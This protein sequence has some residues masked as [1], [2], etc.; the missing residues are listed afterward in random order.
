MSRQRHRFQHRFRLL[1]LASIVLAL[2]VIVLPFD[3]AR[4]NF[5][6]VEAGHIY[7]SAA[8]S[9][10]QTKTLAERHGI[11]TIV[12]LGAFDRD[13]GKET[14][15]QRTAD[16]LG[17]RRHVFRLEGDGTG[18]PNQYVAALKLLADEANHPVLVHCATGAQRT[19]ACIILYRHIIQGRS[20]ESVYPEAFDYRHSP[21]DNWKLMAYL[22]DW[23]DE[24]TSSFESGRPIAG[25][26]PPP[27]GSTKSASKPAAIAADGH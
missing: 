1:A 22:A 6:V 24:I 13:K 8:L 19:G 17:V 18:N 14:A 10:A 15:A 23:T 3:G 20:I 4:R 27:A 5:G 9:P 21:G 25:F 7:R 26:P 2:A 11:K 16:A 12:D